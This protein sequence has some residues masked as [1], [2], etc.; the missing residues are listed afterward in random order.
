MSK[1]IKAAVM[2]ACLMSAT[3]AHAQLG[4][5]G[6]LMGGN[7]GAAA[8]ADV[9]ADVSS[10][11]AQSGALSDAASKSVLAINSAFLSETEFAKFRAD[12]DAAAKTTDPKEKLAKQAA[13][14]ESGSAALTR[15]LESG[16][17]E[18]KMKN[19][20]ANKKKLIG[21]SLKN[22]AIGGLQA[23]VLTKTGQS[24]IQKAGTNPMNL[25]KI[26]PVKDA[27]PLLGKVA[28]DSGGVIAGVLKLAKGANI[29]VPAVKAES[30]FADVAF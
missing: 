15:Q 24:I 16:D 2:A 27:L 19:L 17:L 25:T 29:E 13:L 3:A 18:A 7:K 11:I 30:K 6:G 20:D 9:S 22:F 26:V 10:F 1:M 8:G 21:D 4:G 23:V 14:Y 28:K 12:L 5:L